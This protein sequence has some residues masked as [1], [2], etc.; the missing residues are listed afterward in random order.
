MERT[1][2]IDTSFT[3]GDISRM[4][5]HN[6]MQILALVQE[7]LGSRLIHGRRLRLRRAGTNG[8]GNSMPSRTPRTRALPSSRTR[9]IA[10]ANL[11]IQ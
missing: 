4:V 2:P 8:H 9:D 5:K 11:F 10:S 1:G 6:H 3:H 7:Y